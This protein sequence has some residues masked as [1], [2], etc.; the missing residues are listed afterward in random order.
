MTVYT[1]HTAVRSVLETPHPAGRHARWW[2]RGY[3]SGVKK[4]KIVYRPGKSNSNADA[5]SR[6]PVSAALAEGVSEDKVQVAAIQSSSQQI[7]PT[8]AELFQALLASALATPILFAVEQQRDQDSADLMR[9]LLDHKL[10]ADPDK[11]QYLVLQSLL[12]L[13]ED[14]VLYFTGSKKDGC[15]RVVVPQHLRKQLLEESHRGPMG[16]HFSGSRLF[17]TLATRLF[18]IML[19]LL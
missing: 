2:T 4:V 6:C 9:Y 14:E 13:V 3:S 7:D 12:F 17:Q 16:A 18:H 1:D 19:A 15:K 11:A 5:L 10:P 8:I